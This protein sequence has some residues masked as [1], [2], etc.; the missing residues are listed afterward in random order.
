[1]TLEESRELADK[2]VEIA[3]RLRQVGS[4]LCGVADKLFYNQCSDEGIAAEVAVL[5]K[6]LVE[7]QRSLEPQSAYTPDLVSFAGV[8]SP[9]E[10]FSRKEMRTLLDTLDNLLVAA[11]FEEVDAFIRSLRVEEENST[12]LVAILAF[13]VVAKNK[14]ES[15]AGFLEKVRTKLSRDIS[16]EGVRQMLAGL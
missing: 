13:T 9:P 14:L 3:D 11:K 8:V 7:I 4:G 2:L 16:E 6:Q 10:P 15:R 1:V 5:S 12:K